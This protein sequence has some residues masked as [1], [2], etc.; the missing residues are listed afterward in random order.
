MAFKEQLCAAIPCPGE[1]IIAEFTPGLS[2][3]TGAG[4]IG[5]VAT[6]AGSAQ[7][8]ATSGSTFG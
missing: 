8:A 5:V 7:A 3:H 2:V 1:V 4:L 6:A